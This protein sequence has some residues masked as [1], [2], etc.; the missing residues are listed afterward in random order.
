[1]GAN[2]PANN[3]STII[4]LIF[5]AANLDWCSRSMVSHMMENRNTISKE[6]NY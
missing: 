3:P 1:M 6:K 2:L 5:I 4:L